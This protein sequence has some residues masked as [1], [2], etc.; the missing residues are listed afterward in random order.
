MKPPR[1]LVWFLTMVSIMWAQIPS[2]R[3]FEYR[4][5]GYEIRL[6][7]DIQKRDRSISGATFNGESTRSTN[8]QELELRWDGS[9]Y[10]PNLLVYSLTTNL[11]LNQNRMMRAGESDPYSKDRGFFHDYALRGIL[12]QKKPYSILVGYHRKYRR[13][14]NNFYEDTE[15]YSRRWSLQGSW[16][17]PWVP[18]ST[19]YSND[20]RQEFYGNREINVAEK[21]WGLSG[22]WGSR[23]EP[24]GS[25]R[26]NRTQVHRYEKEL[27]DILLKNTTLTTNFTYPFD[28][29]GRNVYQTSLFGSQ[30]VGTDS[31]VNITWNHMGRME[32]RKNLNGSANYSYRFYETRSSRSQNHTFR[33]GMQHQLYLSLTTNAELQWNEYI[34]SS[35]QKR[36]LIG[37]VNWDYTKKL[38]VGRLFGK[39]GY[40][41]HGE[42]IRSDRGIQRWGE[43][44]HN[45]S[46]LPSAV[47]PQKGV[48][49]ESIEVYNIE[50]TVTYVLQLDYQVFPY[51][52]TF[53]IQRVPGSAIPD[54]A[55]VMIRFLYEGN[56]FEKTNYT[57]W[58][59]GL[60]YEFQSFWGIVVGFSGV[61]ARYPDRTAV[62][63]FTQD[64]RRDVSWFCR[65]NYPPF[66]LDLKREASNSKITPYENWSATVDG[67]LGSYLSQYLLARAQFGTQ[68]LPLRDDRQKFSSVLLRY[69]RRL[70]RNLRAEVSWQQ[71]SVQGSLNELIERKWDVI[72]KYDHTKVS[73]SI[74]YYLVDTQFFEELEYSQQWVASI[75]IRS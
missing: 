47:I 57:L 21:R 30:I 26:L 37:T 65:V 24:N 25:F 5:K 62:T 34:E 72:L 52:T 42:R 56:T 66:N 64:E 46:H 74:E 29:V 39:L 38:P 8:F 73:F 69:F 9:V 53:I 71:R 49:E 55:E 27:Y 31:I 10:H 70:S 50:G 60:T 2:Y 16:R 15:D 3:L 67:I 44:Y 51:G 40:E 22:G 58:N 54:S 75:S 36:D 6:S 28:E 4:L 59:Y 1:Q 63:W 68:I 23:Q 14:N 18:F 32:L 7:T 48:V 12:L 17:N 41:P 13:L 11:G 20:K 61:S 33:T 43:F 19:E 45:F 35:Y